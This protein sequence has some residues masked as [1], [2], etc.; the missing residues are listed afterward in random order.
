MTF[1]LTKERCK[2]INKAKEIRPSRPGRLIRRAQFIRR[3]LEDVS[4]THQSVTAIPRLMNKEYSSLATQM[5]CQYSIVSRGTE[6]RRS[7]SQQGSD[8]RFGYINI[9][10]SAEQFWIRPLPHGVPGPNE[11]AL[12]CRSL[13]LAT[14]ALARIQ[15]IAASAFLSRR[16]DLQHDTPALIVGSGAVALG[17]ALEL[18]RLGC[19]DVVISTNSYE[20]AISAPTDTGISITQ[21]L[22]DEQ[23]FGMV[24]DAVCNS[25][26]VRLALKHCER[27][28]TIGLLGSP[29]A[30]IP[31]DLYQVHRRNLNVLGLHELNSSDSQRQ[32]L[33]E[34]IH[35]WITLNHV[36]LAESLCEIHSAKAF[37]VAYP[38]LLEQSRPFLIHGFD[39]GTS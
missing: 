38:T 29:Y 2:T 13:S 9:A 4:I 14:V 23:M 16:K 11:G 8:G 12:R 22:T 5:K 10:Q 15:L 17:A 27:N 30:P 20:A 28:G 32:S 36:A 37:H 19:P 18:R 33:L 7:C 39:W 34:E 3:V 6:R 31:V 21:E 1:A 35:H 25:Q 26:S 24:I